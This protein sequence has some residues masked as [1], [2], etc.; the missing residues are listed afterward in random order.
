MA[1]SD[2][3]C[4]QTSH[5]LT[6]HYQSSGTDYRFPPLV[7]NENRWHV[8]DRINAIPTSEVPCSE[9][10]SLIY[11]LCSTFLRSLPF[12]AEMLRFA[13]YLVNIFLMGSNMLTE[14]T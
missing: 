2:H 6:S 4:V 3:C 8:I 10:G 12:K 9:D 11:W 7:L 13:E 14:H 5:H 1:Q